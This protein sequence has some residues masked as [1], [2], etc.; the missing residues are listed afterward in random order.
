M[1]PVILILVVAVSVSTNFV[2]NRT[3]FYWIIKRKP[4]IDVLTRGWV[5]Q[6]L[7]LL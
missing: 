2:K 3:R 1:I 4:N 6:F 7:T 5:M